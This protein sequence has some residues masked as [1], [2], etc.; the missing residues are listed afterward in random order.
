ML[1]INSQF[2]AIE[3]RDSDSSVL[4]AFQFF[5]CSET[6]AAMPPKKKAKMAMQLDSADDCRTGLCIY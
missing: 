6:T 2:H 3:P 1:C 4:C 5:V